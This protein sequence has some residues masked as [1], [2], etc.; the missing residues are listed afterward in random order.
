MGPRPTLPDYLPGIGRATSGQNVFYAVGHQH[1][2]LTLAAPTA[3]LIADL[4]AGRN[5]PWD[6]RALD[7]RRFGRVRERGLPPHG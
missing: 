4:V 7:L 5:T 2:G 3:R 1:L 6:I